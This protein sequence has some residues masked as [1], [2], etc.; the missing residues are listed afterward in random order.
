MKTLEIDK[1][2]N[3]VIEGD[4]GVLDG[5]DALAQDVKTMISLQIKE[6]AYNTNKGIDWIAFLQTNDLQ[7]LLSELEQQIY[8]DSRVASVVISTSQ[9]GNGLIFTINTT[10]GETIN[11][12]SD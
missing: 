5:T 7:K 6:Y 10:E 9:E 1:N 8:S 2:N 11:V 12:A 4:M 3:L